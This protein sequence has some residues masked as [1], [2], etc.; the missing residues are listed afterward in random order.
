[1]RAKS[2]LLDPTDLQGGRSK[3]YLLPERILIIIEAA[4][5]GEKDK[6]KLAADAVKFLTANYS[7]HGVC[8]SNDQREVGLKSAR[9]GSRLVATL[10]SIRIA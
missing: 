9:L 6:F 7:Q 2:A 8:A 4:R 3:V 10:E 5:R 1:M